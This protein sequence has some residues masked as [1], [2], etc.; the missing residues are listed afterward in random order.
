MNKPP[1][2]FFATSVICTKIWFKLLARGR[3]TIVFG[4][5]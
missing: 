5:K 3:H 2:R 1:A 4:L